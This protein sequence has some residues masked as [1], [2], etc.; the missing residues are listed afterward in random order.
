MCEEYLT[1]GYSGA[2]NPEEL[3]TRQSAASASVLPHCS[4]RPRQRPFAFFLGFTYADSPRSGNYSASHPSFDSIGS[5]CRRFCRTALKLPNGVSGASVEGSDGT[6]LIYYQGSDA[7]IN[8]LKGPS[9]PVEGVNYTD[10]TIAAAGVA[11]ADTL[12]AVTDLS[13]GK[14][15]A[16]R[17]SKSSIH[18][19]D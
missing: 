19:D 17:T 16:V 10:S 15:T 4:Q 1:I 3:A 6:T 14:L 2:C 13:N 5:D 12:L 9:P 18:A 7:S 8:Q 11:L